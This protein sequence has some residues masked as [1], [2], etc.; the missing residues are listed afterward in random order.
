MRGL[1]EEAKTGDLYAVLA[2]STK[3]ELDP[4]VR[5]ILS[6]LSNLLNVN[7]CYRRYQPDHTRYHRLIGDELRLFGGNTLMNLRRLG[8][9]PPYDEVVADVC[10]KLSVPYE[11]GRTVANEAN[12][13]DIFLEQRWQ[14]LE[15]AQREEL[16][17]SARKAAL[18]KTSHGGWYA[19]TGSFALMSAVFV[20]PGSAAL[21]ISLLDPSYRVTVPCV[22]QVA[23]LRRRIIEERR[24]A[25][26][27]Q[28]GS[29]RATTRV[30]GHASTSLNIIEEDG[31]RMLALTSIGEP[32]AG[33]W[34]T[35]EAGDE[36]IGRLT[37]LLQAVPAVATAAEVTG[38]TGTRYM[39]VVC[40]GDLVNAISGG[41]KRAISVVDGKP[42]HAN[43]FS[44]DKLT[45]LASASAV[46]NIASIA[47]A[48]K[49]LADISEKLSALS[50][51]VQEVKAFQSDERLAD[52]T[53]AVAYFEQKAPS[54]FAGELSTSVLGEIER[55]E[56]DLL[57]R[58]HHL[59]RDLG[60]AVDGLREVQDGGWFTSSDF[61][62]EID[63]AQH[64]INDL[65]KQL[66]LCLRAR[67]LGWQLLCQ[68]AE[69]EIGKR[70]RREDI[71]TSLDQ[72]RESGE[73]IRRVSAVVREKLSAAS[74]LWAQSAMNGRRLNIIRASDEA[75]SAIF[76]ER[77]R[78]AN[79]IAKAEE[80]RTALERPFR[81]AWK[82]EDGRVTAVQPLS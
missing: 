72:L 17:E 20:G 64:R 33:A 65:L 42:V 73:R 66:T 18:G 74:S 40:K 13:L 78:I 26:D 2:L 50:D 75:L 35:I 41:G 56:G 21:G 29:R 82:I 9:G 57:S 36:D 68:F 61:V 45:A 70:R 30:D 77:E 69:G 71:E 60:K 5:I 27:I 15:P 8:E 59:E 55:R 31:A 1:L 48:Q 52:L 11:K 58:Q 79:G 28:T 19:K 63:K 62:D 46:M 23:F 44:A 32:D 14:A 80:M 25:G 54:I 37:A 67:A 4:L 81:M 6:K 24:G 51:D 3:E 34:H 22:L 16:M 76:M 10:W 39:E 38:M 7:E 43:L 53:A 49:H 12:L 47:L